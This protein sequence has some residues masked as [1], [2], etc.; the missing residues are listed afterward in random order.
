M[1]VWAKENRSK[2][3]FWSGVI[4]GWSALML[5]ST[6][7]H[8]YRQIAQLMGWAAFFPSWLKVSPCAGGACAVPVKAD[9]A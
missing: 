8:G 1:L 6:L 4:V 7:P 2:L 3:I 5:S 9:Q